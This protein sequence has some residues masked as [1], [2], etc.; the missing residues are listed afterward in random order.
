[1]MLS[2]PTSFT[3]VF[4]IASALCVGLPVQTSFVVLALNHLGGGVETNITFNLSRGPKGYP[5]WLL[6]DRRFW[7]KSLR[8]RGKY[9]R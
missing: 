8:Y 4:T 6:N 5:G 2:V 1:M 9:F 7:R 3:R